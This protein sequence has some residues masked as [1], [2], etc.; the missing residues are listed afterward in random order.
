[1]AL[2]SFVTSW[3]KTFGMIER[4]IARTWCPQKVNF[5]GAMVRFGA[6]GEAHADH[7]LT[8]SRLA[9]VGLSMRRT[10]RRL[11]SFPFPGRRI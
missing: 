7:V 3:L 8:F 9:A 1:V 6:A 5:L 2:V 4:I 11:L 10:S